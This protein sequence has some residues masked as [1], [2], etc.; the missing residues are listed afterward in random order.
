MKL[1]RTDAN[2]KA[3]ARPTLEFEFHQLT[4]FGGIVVLQELYRSLNLIDRKSFI[5]A[6]AARSIALKSCFCS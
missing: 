4:A 1:S 6:K 3:H 5:G 2:C